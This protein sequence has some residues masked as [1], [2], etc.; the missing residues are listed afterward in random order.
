VAA[1][2]AGLIL[3]VPIHPALRL[4]LA[5]PLVLFLP[6]Y[7][8]TAALFP[9]RPF[10][11]PEL[12]LFSVGLSLTATIIGGF[13]LNWTPWGMQT[14]SWAILAAGVT[15]GASLVAAMRQRRAQ[16]VVAAPVKIGLDVRQGLLLGLA[17]IVAGAAIG[18]AQTPM[19]SSGVLGYTLLW[20]LPAGDGNPQAVRLGMSSQELTP[21][22]YRLQLNVDGQVVREY[23]PITLVPGDEWEDV[24]ELTSESSIVEALLYRLEA[25][26]IVYRQVWLRRGNVAGE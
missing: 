23:S 1:A 19:P 9:K 6:G 13:V 12:L 4:V 24:V 5:L 3:L 11:L 17:A 22:T 15:V 8:I 18:L 20:L 21:T 2:S 14:K 26:E 7:A 10:G 25:P 16:P